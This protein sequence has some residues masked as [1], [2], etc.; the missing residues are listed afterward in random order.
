M[1]QYKAKWV[2]TSSGLTLP[3]HLNEFYARFDRQD[4]AAA[5][6]LHLHPPS[7][8]VYICT[9]A[10]SSVHMCVGVEVCVWMCVCVFAKLLLFLTVLFYMWDYFYI[11]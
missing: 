4:S 3:D 10:W 7:A 1:T 6:S 2:T 8:F 5:E 11:V 9:C